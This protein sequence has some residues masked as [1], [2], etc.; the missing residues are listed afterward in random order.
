MNA[1]NAATAISLSA[2]DKSVIARH[3]APTVRRPNKTAIIAEI[4]FERLRS[5]SMHEIRSS[6]LI[7]HGKPSRSTFAPSA[8]IGAASHHMLT[9]G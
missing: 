4:R 1:G 9:E 6:L 8:V 7:S 5:A 3:K 2:L